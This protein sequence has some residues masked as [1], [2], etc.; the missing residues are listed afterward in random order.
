MFSKNTQQTFGIRQESRRI[1]GGR[2]SAG[3]MFPAVRLRLLHN[4]LS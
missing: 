4:N 2:R 1:V 3:V